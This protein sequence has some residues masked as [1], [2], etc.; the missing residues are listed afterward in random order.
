M[1]EFFFPVRKDTRIHCC[2][3]TP[4]G[5][6]RGVIQ[7]VH[8]IAEYAARYEELAKV[9]TDRGFVVVG[10]DHMGHGKSISEQIPRPAS[11]AAGWR[12]S[13]TA[14]VCCR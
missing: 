11:T 2:Q 8:G 9:F 14:T 1:K 4:E 13:P 6:P 12:R 10:E 5:K 3:W 7:I